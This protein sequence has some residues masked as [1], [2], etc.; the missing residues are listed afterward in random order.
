MHKALPLII[1]AVLSIAIGAMAHAGSHT[2]AGAIDRRKAVRCKMLAIS[3]TLPELPVS[4]NE[5]QNAICPRSRSGTTEIENPAG[6]G[7]RANDHPT[8]RFSADS[9]PR[10]ETTS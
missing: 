8:R 7:R 1:G 4:W 6:R 9:L 10:F 2:Q 5:A 3:T